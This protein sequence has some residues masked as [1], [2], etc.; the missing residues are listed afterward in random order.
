[1][2]ASG[3]N[4]NG[5]NGSGASNGAIGNGTNSKPKG[6]P[7]EPD[8]IRELAFGCRQYVWSKLK[9]ELDGTPETLPILDHYVSLIRADL[10]QGPHTEPLV[11]RAIAAYFGTVVAMSIDGFW[12]AS[13]A[14]DEHG[15]WICARPVYLAINPLGVTYD[16]IG[17]TAEHTGPSSELQLDRL[18]RDTV[19]QRLG[20]LPQLSEEEY[21]T[22]SSRH[23]AL[24]IA[25]AVLRERRHQAG[26]SDLSFTA[27][28]YGTL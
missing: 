26:E 23:E 16:V 19:A 17:M 10:Q 9:I 24:D 1:V 20:A 14:T 6:G 13:S 21:F 12:K 3:S 8:W 27:I 11:T 18:Q 22:F 4:G 15:W 7:L 25:I 2:V 28:D 5:S